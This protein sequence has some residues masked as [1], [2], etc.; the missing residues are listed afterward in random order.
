MQDSF[1]VMYMYSCEDLFNLKQKPR[2]NDISL[3]L[4]SEYYKKY[5]M[6]FKFRYT[7]AE[8][9]DDN[10]SYM[11]NAKVAWLSKDIEYRDFGLICSFVNIFFFIVI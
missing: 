7:F 9:I 4:L 11:H 5:L 3:K 2:I 10:N 6:P 1:L 8:N